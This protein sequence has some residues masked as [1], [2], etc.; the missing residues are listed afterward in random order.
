MTAISNYY[1]AVQ[2]RADRWSHLKQLAAERNGSKVSAK[3]AKLLDD[4]IA[5]QF[6]ILAPIETYWAFPGI[7]AFHFMRRQFEHG[8]FDDLAISS[9]RVVRALS[10]GA[11][12]RRRITLAADEHDLE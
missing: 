2:L 3:R 6:E 10:S 5:E 8:H 4:K 7:A 1:S 11:Y 9:R 12:R